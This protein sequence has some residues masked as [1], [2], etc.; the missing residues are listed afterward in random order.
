VDR[1]PQTRQYKELC[2]AVNSSTSSSIYSDN[3]G[4]MESRFFQALLGTDYTSVV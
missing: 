3:M 4:E 1:E 2:N